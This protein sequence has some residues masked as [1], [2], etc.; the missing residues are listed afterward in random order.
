MVVS[1]T[2][3]FSA[4]DARDMRGASMLEVLL[5]LAVVVV[6]APF[7]YR[8]VA[9]IGH[10]IRDMA[11][12]RDIIANRDS[13]LN[14]VRMNQDRWPDYAQIKL[15]D[16]ELATI[17]DAASAGFVDK[18]MVRGAAVTDVYL[19]YP[20]GGTDLRTAK[21]VRHIGRDAALVGDDGVAYGDTWAVAAPD[22]APGDLIY[23]VSRDFSGEDKSKY[24]HR[25]TSG[26]DDLNVMMRDLDMGHFNLYDIGTVSADSAR[27]ND[28]S[29]VFVTA[30][31]LADRNVFFVAGSI[32]DG[33]A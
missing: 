1:N 15:S 32:M 26:D 8:Q 21:I 2:R 19:A 30:E 20:M 18:Y 10:D 29:T 28:T 9:D 33:K 17:S 22:F 3:I 7:V 14:F 16:D 5:A 24:L 31:D 12:A 27:G 4:G 13:A 25:G 23:R 11:M 6:L